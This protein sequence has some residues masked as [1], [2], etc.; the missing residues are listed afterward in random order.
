MMERQRVNKDRDLDVSAALSAT[1]MVQK[2]TAP[3]TQESA[4]RLREGLGETGGE[5]EVAEEQADA[6][7]LMEK[8]GRCA[9]EILAWNC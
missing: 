3:G 6:S 7:K 8:R 9:V 2:W 4:W 1:Q 5:D